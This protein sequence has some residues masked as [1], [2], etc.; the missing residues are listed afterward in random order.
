VISAPPA[1]SFS[2]EPLYLVA[3][4]GAGLLYARSARRERVGAGRITLFAIGLVL[5][6]AP[7]NSPLETV[8][9]H[10]LLL[11]HLL[12]NAIIADWAP[13]LLI[14]GLT[15]GM[16]EAIARRGGSLLETLSRPGI[17]LVIWLSAWYGTH[18]VPLYE[19]A[20]RHPWAL[21]VE[22][23]ILLGAGLIFWWPVLRGAPLGLPPGTCLLY[24]A[25]A[26]AAASFLGLAFTFVQH[27]FYPFY[28]EAPRLWG[29]SAGEDQNLG[30][31][32]MNA[33]QSI[34]FIAA[35]AYVFFRLLEGDEDDDEAIGPH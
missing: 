31:V 23:A 6:A 11:G 4:A 34:V 9:T 17:S 24:L 15:A 14:L 30:G 35:I 16:K 12:Q 19:L 13:P 5:V 18:A 21:N 28:R 7:L 22:H 27:P 10:Y 32:L 25:T 2:F 33:E 29:L 1:S 3:A 26:F 20:L 8:A